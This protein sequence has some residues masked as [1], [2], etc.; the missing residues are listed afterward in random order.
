VLALLTAA[1]QR[2]ASCSC[3]A[4]TSCYGCLRSYSNQRL[5]DELSRGAARDLL[6]LVLPG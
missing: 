6:R 1:Y 5:H 3:G 4:E 2:V